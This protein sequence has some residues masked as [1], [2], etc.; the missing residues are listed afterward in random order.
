MGIFD[1][2]GSAAPVVPEP[3]P[4]PRAPP[5]PGAEELAARKIQEERQRRQKEAAE[6]A[7]REAELRAKDPLLVAL[8]KEPADTP[9]QRGA[10]SKDRAALLKLQLQVADAIRL[11]VLAPDVGLDWPLA[12]TTEAEEKAVA[13]INQL[14]NA[15][16]VKLQPGTNRGAFEDGVLDEV[17]GY[18]PLQPLLEAD[19]VSEVLVN[20]P[21]VVFAERGGQMV[22][23]GRK[24][25]DDDHVERI[26]KRI[27]LPLGRLADAEHPLVDARLP[28]GSRVN[29]VIRP[30]ALDGP[31]L[32]I[33]KFS[34]KK[35]TMDDLVR[36]GALTPEMALLLEALVASRQN[37]V[38][39]GGTGSGKTTV[40]NCLSGFIA[41]AE[42]TVTIEDAAELQLSQRNV[43]RLETKKP[44]PLSPGEVTIRDC[45]RNALRMRPERIVVGE[46]RGGETLDMLQ[47]M[48]TG[49][50]GSMTTVHANDPRAC[51]SR[52]ET[53]VLMG[54]LDLPLG[55]VRRQV[56]TSVN[57]I[58]QAAR[59]RDGSRKIT[60][61]TE[62]QGM[63]GDIVT[64][65]DLFRFVDEG[66]SPEGKV[67]GS[68]Q[69][70]GVRPRCLP[71]F[72]QYGYDLPNS[73]FQDRRKVEGRRG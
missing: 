57:I 68:H 62:I 29:A 36:F 4:P 31:S 42:R 71:V 8:E 53:L 5:G 52:L 15:G 54:G 46:C 56:A 65:A 24:F 63:E 16:A 48:N 7:A 37:I 44:T 9:R 41:E 38:V 18:G 45:V 21:Y 58:V 69:A 50:D 14:V 12:R 64:L 23:T 55:V 6:R 59:L 26:V 73:V 1:R 70:T 25:L 19:S 22:E 39:S 47:A 2:M 35:L 61:I 20:G 30:V 51:L 13:A 33:R 34:K 43:V 66:D 60:H 49:H 10:V 72:K 27:V 3:D 67:L 11:K 40:I 17:F 28:D 32:S